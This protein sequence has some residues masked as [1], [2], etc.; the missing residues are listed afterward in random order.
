MAAGQG[1]APMDV[2]LPDELIDMD[3]DDKAPSV[4]E[5]LVYSEIPRNRATAEHDIIHTKVFGSPLSVTPMQ[6][7][8]IY[9]NTSPAIA[10]SIIEARRKSDRKLVGF[11]LASTGND[12]TVDIWS[13]C[14]DIDLQVKGVVEFLFQ[15]FAR[16]HGFRQIAL[17]VSSENNETM[18]ELGRLLLYSSIGFQLTSGQYVQDVFGNDLVIVSNRT[19]DTVN[20]R[21]TL[22]EEYDLYIGFLR[23]PPGHQLTMKA[24]ASEIAVGKRELLHIK[25]KLPSKVENNFSITPFPV[26]I[27]ALLSLYHMNLRKSGNV[28]ETIK[29]P[30]NITLVTFSMPGTTLFGTMSQFQQMVNIILRGPNEYNTFMKKFQGFSSFPIYAIDNATFVNNTRLEASLLSTLF[31]LQFERRR[32]ITKC[33]GTEYNRKQTQYDIQTYAPGM[34]CLNYGMIWDNSES[35]EDRSLGIGTYSKRSRS[36]VGELDDLVAEGTTLQAFLQKVHEMNP[37]VPTTVF[38][39][40]CAVVGDQG[41]SSFYEL[42][43]RRSLNYT[44]PWAEFPQSIR[45]FLTTPNGVPSP[46]VPNCNR[47]GGKRRPTSRRLLSGPKRTVRRSSSSSR[48]RY[49]RRQRALRS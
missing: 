22:S 3:Y 45:S 31:M 16:Q 44:V 4:N 24:S 6:I 10:Q 17:T 25:R 37:D 47:T 21:N 39:F 15:T 23:S 8:R 32:I 20:V 2:E 33:L 38:L 14:K 41:Y 46:L 11:F 35:S 7:S 34:T 19:H 26:P 29:I 40:G 13:V 36:R 49:T 27:N 30:N 9:S 43:H 42:S 5:E 28:L 48:K 18:T 1:P 12:N